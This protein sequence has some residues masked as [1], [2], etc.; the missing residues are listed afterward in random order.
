M[1]EISK[2]QLVVLAESKLAD[3]QLLLQAGRGDNAYY[4][5]GYAIEL[6]LKA[7]L[8]TQFKNETL[9]D[10]ALLRDLFVHDI[11]KLARSSKI[12][13]DLKLALDMDERF[14]ASWKTVLEWDPISRYGSR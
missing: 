7:I 13:E 3:A 4:L 2:A 9:P 6:M 12:D 5:A 1:G 10:R 14:N 8:S 11:E